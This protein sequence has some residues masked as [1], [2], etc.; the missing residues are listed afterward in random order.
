MDVR[1]YRSRLLEATPVESCCAGHGRGREQF[2]ETAADA[3]DASVA[4]ESESEDSDEC[5]VRRVAAPSR[6]PPSAQHRA[7]RFALVERDESA[8]SKALWQPQHFEI[9]RRGRGRAPHRLRIQTGGITT[10]R[11]EV[12]SA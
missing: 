4:G 7:P 11:D 12:T 2:I 9:I 1:A 10:I 5:T 6:G 8:R 3:G